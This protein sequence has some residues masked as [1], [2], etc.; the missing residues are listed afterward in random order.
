MLLQKLQ[1]SRRIRR[2]DKAARPIVKDL[3]IVPLNI[4]IYGEKSDESRIYYIQQG[5]SVLPDKQTA[6]I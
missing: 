1:L 2:S 5:L 3:G 4:L 6:L